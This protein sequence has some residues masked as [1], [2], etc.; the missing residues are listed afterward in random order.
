MN[1]VNFS[2]SL[3]NFCPVMSQAVWK[4]CCLTS[5]PR[6]QNSAKKMFWRIPGKRTNSHTPNRLDQPLSWLLDINEKR[7]LKKLVWKLSIS[8]QLLETVDLLCAKPFE[9]H[10]FWLQ[11]QGGK[12]TDFQAPPAPTAAAPDKLS[13]P[14][15]TLLPRHQ[16]W[17]TSARETL[18]VDLYRFCHHYDLC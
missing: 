14:N 9:N 17:N 10:V 6:V 11:S 8:A 18:A 5:I 1:A 13:D 16:G 2:P 12:I 7:D 3:W 4:P 15:L